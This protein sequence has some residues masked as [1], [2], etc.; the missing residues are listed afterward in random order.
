[1]CS[2]SNLRQSLTYKGGHPDSGVNLRPAATQ[3]RRQLKS[4][5]NCVALR[6]TLRNAG[7]ILTPESTQWSSKVSLVQIL[8]LSVTK[9]APRKG[10]KLIA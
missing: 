7:M 3:V 4:G 2:A 5:V 8:E 1:M 9:F 10:L 6:G